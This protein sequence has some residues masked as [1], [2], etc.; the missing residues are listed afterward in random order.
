M[1]QMADFENIIKNHTSEDGSIPAEAIAKLT[2]AISTAVGNEFVEK[3]RYKAKLDEIDTLKS[4]K[5]TAEDNATTAGK[6]KTKYD[7]LKDEFDTFKGEQA[8]KETRAAKEKAVTEYLKSKNVQE[9][10]LKLAMRSLNAEIEAAELDGGKLKDTKAF[11]TLLDGDLKGLITTTTEKPAPNPVNPPKH[12]PAPAEP[13]SLA[14]ALREKYT[15][16]G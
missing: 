1:Y 9:G 14:D 2:K 6:W 11:D 4:E 7:A 10:N 15:P 8:K 12:D 3:T 16:K 5:Q 13:H